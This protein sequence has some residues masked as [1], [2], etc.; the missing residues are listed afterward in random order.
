VL[1]VAI[2]VPPVAILP[3]AVIVLPVTVVVPRPRVTHLLVLQSHAY[4]K[5]Y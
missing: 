1:P 4:S 2:V 3:L 5:K